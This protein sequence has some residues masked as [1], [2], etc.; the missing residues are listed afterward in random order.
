MIIMN[1]GIMHLMHTFFRKNA[2]KTD[3]KLREYA[4]SFIASCVKYC[5]IDTALFWTLL[6]AVEKKI[7]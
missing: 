6:Y 1:G 4:I 7:Y 3:A 5:L 2:Q